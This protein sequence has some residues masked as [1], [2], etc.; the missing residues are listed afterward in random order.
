MAILRWM[1]SLGVPPTGIPTRRLA[2]DGA[3]MTSL[4]IRDEMKS[5]FD[6]GWFEEEPEAEAQFKIGPYRHLSR[7]SPLYGF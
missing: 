6:R 1:A 7:F 4:R 2:H 3:A 5:L